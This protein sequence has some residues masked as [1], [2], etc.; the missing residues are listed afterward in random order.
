MKIEEQFSTNENFNNKSGQPLTRLYFCLTSLSGVSGSTCRTYAKCRYL[1]QSLLAAT[2]TRNS[3]STPMALPISSIVPR[4]KHKL[5]NSEK[6][7]LHLTQTSVVLCNQV[8]SRGCLRPRTFV[9][10]AVLPLPYSVIY[11]SYMI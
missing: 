9:L 5:P 11:V 4:K 8:T 3:Y 2:I 7:T 10:N 6:I 1:L